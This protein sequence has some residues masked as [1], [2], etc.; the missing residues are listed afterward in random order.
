MKI[1]KVLLYV[2]LALVGI[3]IILGLVGPKTYK[4]ER[5]AVITASPDAIWPHVSSVR[6]QNTWSPFVE[7]DTAMVIEYAGTD[8]EV[9]S[10]SKWTSKKMGNGE[11]TITS[12][13]P[14]K[15]VNTHLKFIQPWGTSESDAYLNMEPD[16]AGTKVTWGFGGNNDFVGRMF[17]SIMNMDKMV[18]P[19]YEK[20]LTNL[21]TL[22][23]AAPPAAMGK[24][25][26]ITEGQYPG[27][28]FL[29]VRSNIN[30]SEMKSFYEK[31]FQAIMSEIQKSKIT[32]ATMPLGIYYTWDM[33][34]G[35]TDMAAA[36]GVPADTNEPAG[37]TRVTVPANKSLTM[38]YTGGYSG[39]GNAHMGFDDYIRTNKLEQLSPVLEE[40]ITDP[41]SE[42]D[43]NKYM[44]KITYFVK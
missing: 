1:L 9:G 15:S 32:P 7:E 42:P 44:T 11:Q 22:V 16:P 18:G 19:M 6:S 40:Y 8:G 3:G 14:N 41:G 10:S 39:L 26:A 20:G 36:I 35:T 17:G 24:K 34:K 5:S 23:A 43:S 37:L 38:M 27:G 28:T 12:L 4:V 2:L 30:M 25:Y 29:T 21:Q 13:D 33:E 31:N